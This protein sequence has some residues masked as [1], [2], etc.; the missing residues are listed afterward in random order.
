MTAKKK[1]QGQGKK[2]RNWAFVAYPDS[3]P[4]NWR[5]VLAECHVDM[6]IS[7]LHDSDVN[8]DG[9]VKKSHYHVVLHFPGPVTAGNAQRVSDSVNATQV[10]SVASLRSYARYLC[11]MDNPEKA[12]YALSDVVVYGSIDYLDLVSS[13]ADVD[14]AISDMERWCDEYGVYSYA[15]LCRYA[16]EHRP[17][18]ARLLRHRCTTH[19]K[20]YLQSCQW[21]LTNGIDPAPPRCDFADGSS[22]KPQSE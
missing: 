7:P 8:A 20:A 21:E 6:L 19:M 22:V 12:Q 2:T 15:C 5:D 16:R 10:Q 14:S 1:Q 17:D 13:A 18:W 3:L 4:D 9:E 11:H